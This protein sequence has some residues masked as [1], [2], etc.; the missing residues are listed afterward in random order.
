MKN[1]KTYARRDSATTVLRK[2]GV[3][4]RDYSLFITKENDAYVLDLGLLNKFKEQGSTEH[5][6]NA[7]HGPR[8]KGVSLKG[9]ADTPEGKANKASWDGASRKQDKRRSV[10]AVARELILI[11]KTNDEVWQA[12]VTEFKL[13]DG[14]RHYPSWYR[15]QLKRDGKLGA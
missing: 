5:A 3:P 10:S 8:G 12:L 14:K 7:F 6:T 9:L 11:G 1:L 15:A 4:T 13:D 2:A